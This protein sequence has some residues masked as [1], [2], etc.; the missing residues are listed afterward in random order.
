MD[1][2][3]RR[4]VSSA[5]HGPICRRIMKQVILYIAT[6]AESLLHVSCFVKQDSVVVF[7]RTTSLRVIFRVCS[8]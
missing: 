1:E 8:T 2:T 5:R 7:Y 4:A 3:G 6:A